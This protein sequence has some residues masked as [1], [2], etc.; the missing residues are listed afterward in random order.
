MATRTRSLSY[1]APQGTLRARKGI[2]AHHRAPA[3]P[4]VGTLPFKADKGIHGGP[5][6]ARDWPQAIHFH[7]KK[8]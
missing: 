3:P 8:C 2:L 5:F 6:I 4:V 1:D 7:L